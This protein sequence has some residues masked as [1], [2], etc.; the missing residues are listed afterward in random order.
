MED[1]Q[2]KDLLRSLPENPDTFSRVLD[3]L[4][5]SAPQA[6][7]GTG[8]V[9]SRSSGGRAAF[10]AR[11]FSSGLTGSGMDA[12][13]ASSLLQLG[14]GVA[15]SEVPGAPGQGS[16][17]VL[18]YVQRVVGEVFGEHGAIPI[19]SAEVSGIVVS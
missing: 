19:A 3:A 11:G 15:L 12:G 16:V 14:S 18:E 7:A 17:P 13:G 9:G 5:A 1:E 8:A 10:D 4:F 2:L 6:R